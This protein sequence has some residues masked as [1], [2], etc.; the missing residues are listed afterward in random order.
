M[1]EVSPTKTLLNIELLSWLRSKPNFANK[2]KMPGKLFFRL[3][4]KKNFQE[5]E[6]ILWIFRLSE[7]SF[8][9]ESEQTSSTSD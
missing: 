7:F 9:P 6:K 3:Y 2:A 1:F 8:S 5:S 4:P